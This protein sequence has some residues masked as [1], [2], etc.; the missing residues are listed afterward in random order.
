MDIGRK[1]EFR[2]KKTG[3]LTTFLELRSPS[4]ESVWIKVLRVDE[5]PGLVFATNILPAEEGT[6]EIN[7]WMASELWEYLNP[8]T[9]P[10]GPVSDPL[11]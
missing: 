6:D 11:D 7:R 4:P 5:E 1:W 10:A 2:E 3:I 9:P 8:E